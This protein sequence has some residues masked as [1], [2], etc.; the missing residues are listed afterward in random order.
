MA[1]SALQN[2]LYG[3][4]R[5][6]IDEETENARIFLENDE[7]RSETITWLS[8]VSTP[9]AFNRITLAYSLIIDQAVEQM[10]RHE[11]A[12]IEQ[13]DG[14]ID[15]KYR[16]K[17][18][19]RKIKDLISETGRLQQKYASDTES[20]TGFVL[21]YLILKL[22]NILA[23]LGLRY[24]QL[25]PD[26]Q[27]KPGRIYLELLDRELP[28]PSPYWRTTG[29]YEQALNN[30]LM[31]LEPGIDPTP[32]QVAEIIRLLTE[33]GT[34]MR[35]SEHKYELLEVQPILH[36]A[37]NALFLIKMDAVFLHKNH[38]RI[39]DADYCREWVEG[40]KADMLQDRTDDLIARLCMLRVTD[41]WLTNCMR[42]VDGLFSDV[43]HS[44]ARL[45]GQELGALG[46]SSEIDP[47][48][49]EKANSKET[50]DFI[51]YFNK[52]FVHKQELESALGVNRKTLKSYLEDTNVRSLQ[53]N[54][55]V[56]YVRADVEQFF[57]DKIEKDGS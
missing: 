4:W 35:D 12:L 20:A 6:W 10:G 8:E 46:I 38:S 40:M 22:V 31:R 54:A 53:L 43:G 15:R 24:P 19:S 51:T 14:V 7:K 44:D 13:S 34:T 36:H 56:W 18:N 16:F 37:E 39:E 50:T 45:W 3:P 48:H 9:S 11:F 47:E 41:V 28:S 49:S 26:D 33:M 1:F 52:K 55:N 25:V 30:F 23:D 5:P 32:Q 57:E 2:I 42:P 29:W 17:T 21:Q 27:L